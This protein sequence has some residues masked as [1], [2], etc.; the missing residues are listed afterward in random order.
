MEGYLEKNRLLRRALDAMPIPVFVIDRAFA[1]RDRNA[2]GAAFLGA[3]AEQSLSRLCGMA[4]HCV[5]ALEAPGGCGTSPVCPDCA[6]RGAIGESV[7]QGAPVRRRWTLRRSDGSGARRQQLFVT[8]AELPEAGEPVS[9]VVIEDF[10]EFAELRSLV[11]MCAACKKIRNDSDYWE[12]VEH[13][14]ARQM[15]LSFT[16][17]LCPECLEEYFAPGRPQPGEAGG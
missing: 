14:L 6:L 9:L 2:A 10:T 12:Q 7:A 3:A 11:P 16:H 17:G 5:N 1:L 4:L 13:Y 8:A 15:D